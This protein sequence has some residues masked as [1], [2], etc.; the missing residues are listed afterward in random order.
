MAPMP[1]RDDALWACGTAIS[2][3]SGQ[4]RLLDGPRGIQVLP[5]KHCQAEFW[6]PLSAVDYALAARHVCKCCTASTDSCGSASEK[7]CR[8]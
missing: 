5:C 7:L 4:W 6:Q 2:P 3:C 8:Q 1:Q